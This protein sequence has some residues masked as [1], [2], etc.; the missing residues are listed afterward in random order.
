MKYFPE[1]LLRNQTQPLCEFGN[2]N[3]VASVLFY[4]CIFLLQTLS[5]CLVIQFKKQFS[6]FKQHYTHFYTYFH[7][8][9]FQKIKKKTLNNNSQT[10]LPNTSVLS[11]F[12]LFNC[13]HISCYTDLIRISFCDS[14]HSFSMPS[15]SLLNLNLNHQSFIF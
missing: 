5:V 3:T 14:I 2:I 9:V 13:K 10:T 15:L 1:M 12:L 6:H 8:H 4:C 11:H 7:P